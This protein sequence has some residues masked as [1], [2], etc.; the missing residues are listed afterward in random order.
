MMEL[1]A[2]YTPEQLIEIQNFIKA[3][4]GSNETDYVAHE[5]D[6]K[7]VHT[8]IAI[9]NDEDDLKAFASFGMGAR[10]M[11]APEENLKR[12]ELFGFASYDLIMDS[13]ETKVIVTE[14]TRISK[15]P[16]QNNTWIGPG[17][18]INA[19][20]DFRNKFGF[21]FFLFIYG[22]FTVNLSDIGEVNYLNLIPIYEEERNW[23][24]ENGE[25]GFMAEL[26]QTNGS[27]ALILNNQR[28]SLINHLVNN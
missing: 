23:I 18:T 14:I 1:P 25:A 12:I 10:P 27:N 17:H 8:D 19:S 20:D 28:E 22:G 3:N 2:I 13:E 5:I 4:F 24:V 11:N 7:Y 26:M 16:F 15:Y 21:G 9:I 6:S